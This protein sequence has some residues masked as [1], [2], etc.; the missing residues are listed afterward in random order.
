MEKYIG[1]LIE[2]SAKS[3]SL[4]VCTVGKGFSGLIE[5]GI[6]N[7]SLKIGTAGKEFD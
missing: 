6:N 1:E 2:L 4:K 7:Y 5:I 3:N